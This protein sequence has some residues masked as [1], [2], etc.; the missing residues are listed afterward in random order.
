MMRYKVSERKEKKVGDN[1]PLCK[2]FPQF[3]KAEK[4]KSRDSNPDVLE[5]L[6]PEF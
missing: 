5:G 4:K 3:F 1:S 2:D 6:K